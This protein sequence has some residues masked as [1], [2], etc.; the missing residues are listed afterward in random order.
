MKLTYAFYDYLFGI[1]SAKSL[2][3]IA[4]KDIH[5]FNIQSE[6]LF[7]FAYILDG[8]NDDLA[9]FDRA[10]KKIADEFKWPTDPKMLQKDNIKEYLDYKLDLI[11]NLS[12]GDHCVLSEFNN[13]GEVFSIIFKED[14]F[15][16]TC[17]YLQHFK[18][19]FNH[20][21][22]EEVINEI[23]YLNKQFYG[24]YPNQYSDQ[25]E[26]DMIIT[27]QSLAKKMLSK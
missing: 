4:Q 21:E 15:S 25:E 12:L 5:E 14:V 1:A 7:Y 17:Y 19:F 9:D 8:E 26:T 3:E 22:N 24:A 18:H 27:L 11:A 6:S 16:P 20:T 23:V 2:Q 13:V 10:L